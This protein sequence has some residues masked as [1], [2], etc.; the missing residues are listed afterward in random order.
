MKQCRTCLKEKELSDYH[1]RSKSSDGLD[2]YCKSCKYEKHRAR[3]TADPLKVLLACKRSDCKKKGIPFSL[4]L[5]HL[6]EIWTDVCPIFGVK[7]SQSNT[8]ENRSETAQLD[9][10]DPSKGYV[11]GNVAFIS[12]RAN[13]IKYNA[14]VDEL[15]QVANWYEKQ[16]ER[17]TT[18]SKESTLK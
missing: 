15:R 13:R 8:L 10:I 4:T 18:I 9:R 2:Y 16:Q 5:E 3:F 7:M 12:A 1:K 11:D 6:N 17:A 14:T